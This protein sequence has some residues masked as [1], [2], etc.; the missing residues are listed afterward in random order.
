MTL[1]EPGAPG[2]DAP[3]P[4]APDPDAP[5]PATTGSDA[6]DLPNDG[7]GQA[8]SKTVTWHDPMPIA[9]TAGTMSGQEFLRAMA[10]GKV[11]P[12]P[13]AQLFDF[14]PVSVGDGEVS[15]TCSPDESA[16]NPIGMVHGGLVCTILDTVTGCAVHT[17]L[18][19]GVLY[20][21][22]EIKVN[23][24]R[25]IRIEDGKA[26]S[27]TARGWV[28]KPGRR[29]AFAEGEVRDDRGKVVATASSTCL[30]L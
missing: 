12:P 2:S 9:A 20:T 8:R 15:F 17:T 30:V 13:I 28:T 27:L 22:I 29:V 21:S 25:P 5:G 14:R 1:I 3:G 10:D 18:P 6:G 23:Y 16:Y 24:L 19:V 4:D 26:A 7:W 11:P